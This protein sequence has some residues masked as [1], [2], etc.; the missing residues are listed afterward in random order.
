MD[1]MAFAANSGLTNPAS[2]GKIAIVHLTL[3]QIQRIGLDA[4]FMS[5][6]FAKRLKDLDDTELFEKLKKMTEGSYRDFA[7]LSYELGRYIY[8][9]REQIDEKLDQIKTRL[10]ALEGSE[11]HAAE[12]RELKTQRQ[13]LR[14]EKQ[15]LKTLD[16]NRRNAKE[17]P[18]LNATKSE[19]ERVHENIEDILDKDHPLNG[20]LPSSSRERSTKKTED[21]FSTGGSDAPDID[22]DIT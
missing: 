20:H 4:G 7:N 18:E 8:I 15:N 16:A 12:V 14:T 22:V 10:D 3:Q 1:G 6:A 17:L 11:G 9:L 2:S 5:G 21:R 19:V 13:T